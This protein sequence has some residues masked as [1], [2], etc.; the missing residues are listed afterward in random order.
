MNGT[1]LA[2]VLARRDAA[3]PSSRTVGQDAVGH[4]L[5]RLRRYDA[6][7]VHAAMTQLENDGSDRAPAL[8]QVVTATKQQVRRRTATARRD[9]DGCTH[10]GPDRPDCG[11]LGTVLVRRSSGVRDADGRR[12]VR[13]F[14]AA[15]TCPLGDVF[16]DRMPTWAPPPEPAE[17]WTDR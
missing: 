9:G 7:D 11:G 5:D 15:C 6:D 2:H 16:R 14:A 3:W 12:R 1:E 13:E 4:W 17:H 10:A 8:G